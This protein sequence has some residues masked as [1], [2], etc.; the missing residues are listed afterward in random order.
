MRHSKI[1]FLKCPSRC[2]HYIVLHSEQNSFP[3][4]CGNF[5]KEMISLIAFYHNSLLPLPLLLLLC[6]VP[7]LFCLS[8]VY[9][10]QWTA[11][12]GLKWLLCTPHWWSALHA[13]RLRWAPPWRRPW[14]HLKTLCSHPSPESRTESPDQAHSHLFFYNEEILNVSSR[15]RAPHKC[16]DMNSTWVPS[17]RWHEATPRWTEV[18]GPLG[19]H[20]WP[21]IRIIVCFSCE[22]I[23][24]LPPLHSHSDWLHSC[25]N[26]RDKKNLQCCLWV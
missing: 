15:T 14:G 25:V 6:I 4:A 13:P 21:F 12:H 17:L 3:Y 22:L 10:L 5:I 9:C 2:L 11:T 1:T 16:A 26:Y 20:R 24:P 18:R 23:T 7:L 8:F 19:P